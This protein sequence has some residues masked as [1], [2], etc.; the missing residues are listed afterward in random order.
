MDGNV[1]TEKSDIKDKA[2][3]IYIFR[4]IIVEYSPSHGVK[5]TWKIT[6]MIIIK[7]LVHF[8]RKL[9]R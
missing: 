3:S 4:S 5:Y 2:Y 9:S 1:I 8:Y 7:Q 6:F